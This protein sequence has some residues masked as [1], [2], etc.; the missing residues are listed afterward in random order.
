MITTQSSVRDSLNGVPRIECDDRYADRAA[1]G[2]RLAELLLR[3]RGGRALVLALPPGGVAVAGELARALRLPLD[4]LVARELVVRPYPAVVVGALSEGGGL[5]LNRAALRLPDISLGAIWYEA[6]RVANEI[7]A[8]VELYRQGRRLP[9]LN[10]RTVILAD[11]G[12]GSGLVQLAAIRAV[13]RIHASHCIVAT[14]LG[15]SI[16]IARTRRWADELV[17]LADEADGDQV[18]AGHWQP[19]LGDEDAALLL[20]QYRHPPLRW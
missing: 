16:A 4:V 12:L 13:R 15:A 2:R 11:D 17:T 1:A 8:L 19:Q 20:E 3:Y 10:R 7:A 9:F 5:C 6:R 18:D 14:P